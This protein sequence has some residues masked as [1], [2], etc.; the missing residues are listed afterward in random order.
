MAKNMLLKLKLNGAVHDFFVKTTAQNVWL[1]A[2][3]TKTLKERLVEVAADIARVEGVAGAAMTEEQVNGLITAAV[4]QVKEEIL[5]T[6]VA[7]AWD[8]LEEIGTWLEANKDLAATLQALATKHG[9]DIEELDGRVTTIEGKID[10]LEGK[11]TQVEAGD[12]N[13]TIKVDGEVVT[14]YEH[15]VGDGFE[16]IPA[17]GAAG[18]SL[19]WESAGK[20]KWQ[21]LVVMGGDEELAALQDGQIMFYLTGDDEEVVEEPTV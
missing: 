9:E 8:T 5:G 14:V 1:D 15:P 16:H 18:K 17:G 2:A 3:Q 12:V 4:A 10:I 21:D 20:A 6:K 7:E 19:V 13:G 11:S